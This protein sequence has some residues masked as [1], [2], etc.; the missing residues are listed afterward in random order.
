MNKIFH[1][2]TC[3]TC[4]RFLSELQP[5]DGFELREIKS[6]P[7]TEAELDRMKELAGSYEALFSRRAR[8]YR[9][10]RLHEQE[11]DESDYR[12]F[13]LEEYTFLKRP[14][15]LLDDEVFAGSSKKNVAAIRERL[16]R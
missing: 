8:K 5:L 4:Q 6:E 1:L 7:V 14:V 16:G 11:L 12:R 15:V 2:S 3:K 13:L 9:A 10:M